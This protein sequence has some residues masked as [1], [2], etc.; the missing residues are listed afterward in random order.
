SAASWRSAGS[1]ARTIVRLAATSR[2]TAPRLHTVTTPRTTSATSVAS[3]IF[4]P[5]RTDPQV[6]RG[7]AAV[8]A[9][10]LRSGD[11]R[12]ARAMV[13]V[14]RK[15]MGRG[16][17]GTLDELRAALARGRGQG[18][19]LVASIGRDLRRMVERGR[20]ELAGDVG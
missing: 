15:R 20:A 7:P 5:S 13:A 9:V 18:E 16:T 1:V 8:K 10:A 6:P 12:R 14:G 17:Q 4:T 3:T 19:R 11:A 2:L